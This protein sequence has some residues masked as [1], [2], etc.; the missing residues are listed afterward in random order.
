MMKSNVDHMLRNRVVRRWLPEIVELFLRKNEDYGEITSE[1]G[2][3]GEIVE[4]SRKYR[5][6][7]RAV[8]DGEGS[9]FEDAD[10]VIN[11]LVGHLLLLKDMLANAPKFGYSVSEFTNHHHDLYSSTE[12][13]SANWKT[14]YDDAMREL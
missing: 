3:K 11:D 8:W 9:E 6:L 5:K 13:S 12:F 1:F 14:V 10:E 2:P 4:I 7:K